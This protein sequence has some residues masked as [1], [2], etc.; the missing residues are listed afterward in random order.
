[1]RLSFFAAMAMVISKL[2]YAVPMPVDGLDQLP[3]EF[4]Q[5]DATKAKTIGDKMTKKGKDIAK[6]VKKSEP[7]SDNTLKKAQHK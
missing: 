6:D 5:V 2:S 4:I 3:Q 7:E 1:M